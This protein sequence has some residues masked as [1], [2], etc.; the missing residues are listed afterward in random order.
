MQPKAHQEP[1]GIWFKTSLP[2][3]RL[4]QMFYGEIKTLVSLH[5]NEDFSTCKETVN[6]SSDQIDGMKTLTEWLWNRAEQ[7][8]IKVL[9]TPFIQVF[10]HSFCCFMTS[11]RKT[12]IVRVILPLV[13][14]MHTLIPRFP[15]FP[16]DLRSSH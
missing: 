16:C 6:T 14:K 15:W 7:D 12:W 11:V 4:H 9:S 1:I 8:R 5:S 10:C 2:M 13:Y 3:P